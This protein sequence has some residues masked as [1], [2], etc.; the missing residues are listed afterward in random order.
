MAAGFSVELGICLATGLV[1]SSAVT[2]L[3]LVSAGAAFSLVI[4]GAGRGSARDGAAF[5]FSDR[6]QR[7]S[8]PCALGGSVVEGLQFA[9]PELD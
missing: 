5:A 6:P 7:K 9:G 4:S 3:P 2:A 1:L 8:L